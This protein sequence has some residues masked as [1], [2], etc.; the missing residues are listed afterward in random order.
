MSFTS[1]LMIFLLIVMV[2]IA[3]SKIMDS[4]VFRIA[5]ITYQEKLRQ[6]EIEEEIR[7][8]KQRSMEE[9]KNPDLLMEIIEKMGRGEE[10]KIPLAAFDY[11]YRNM[12]KFTII[13]KEGKLTI[14]NEED[15]LHF[16]KIAENLLKISDESRVDVKKIMD[17]IKKQ[18]KDNPI[19]F[20]EHEDGTVV[21]I[22][23][24]KRQFTI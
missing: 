2:F 8:T 7:K 16:K 15:Y 20:Q 4:S 3:L 21:E 22:N 13:D 12:R 14:I 5:V 11:I 18:E 17:S 19:E 1:F 6:K 9:I 10:I 23:H 24:I